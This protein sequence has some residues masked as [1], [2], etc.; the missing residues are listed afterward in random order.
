MQIIKKTVVSITA[1]LLILCSYKT[2]WAQGP[3]DNN[4]AQRP[5]ISI[6]IDD[7]GNN[8]DAGRYAIWL[9]G[10]ITY[11]ILPFSPH[12]KELS[13]LAVSLDKE[14]IL[15]SPM[16]SM[17]HSHHTDPGI[18][19]LDM[20]EQEFKDTLRQ[21]LDFLPNI[22]GINNHMGSLLTQQPVHMKWVMETINQRGNLFFVDSLTTHKSVA[23]QVATKNNI[24][25]IQRDIFL[26]HEAGMETMTD[27]FYNLIKAARFNGSALAIG[28]P[29]PSTTEALHYFIPLLDA[30]E[31]DLVNAS[32]MVKYRRNK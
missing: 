17:G 2:L 4:E 16:Q 29:Y 28:H 25:S 21:N 23:Y 8:L 19:T 27:Q 14:V 7:M 20:N 18:L 11:A 12:G 32:Q 24:P 22:I 3:A 9:P 6:I 1:G 30:L 10:P 15:H 26:D 31:I 13:E 5:A